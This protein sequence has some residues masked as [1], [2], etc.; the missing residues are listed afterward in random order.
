MVL[1]GVGLVLRVENEFSIHI[2]DDE[3]SAAGS[4]A[5]L[6]RLVLKKLEPT[7]PGLAGRAFYCTRKALAESLD[8]PPRSICP[9]TALEPLLPLESRVGIWN[10]VA[11]RAGLRLPE[12]AH[13]GQWKDRMLLLSMAISAVPVIALWW[14]LYALDWLHGIWLFLF[15]APALLAWIV[16]IS[17]VN[18]RLLRASTGRATDF[19]FG[20]ATAGDLS[21]FVLSLNPRTFE[22]ATLDSTRPSMETAWK[23]IVSILGEVPGV[24]RDQ[25]A[26]V[27]EL[28]PQKAKGAE[29]APLGSGA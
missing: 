7:P 17:R 24:D 14:A 23:R 20:I 2:A 18:E 16:L 13:P 25:P 27:V 26:P 8:V 15:S 4:A 28:S 12:L 1:D 29:K 19:P 22:P 11:E 3:A 6:Y 9:E 5:D 10:R 21:L